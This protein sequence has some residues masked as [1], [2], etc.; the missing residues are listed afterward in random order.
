LKTQTNNDDHGSEEQQ[1]NFL[2]TFHY[3]DSMSGAIPPDITLLLEILSPT[4]IK[5]EVI[6]L[7]SYY[8]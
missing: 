1:P 7:L 2:K 3:A 5:V 6:A 8:K 4:T